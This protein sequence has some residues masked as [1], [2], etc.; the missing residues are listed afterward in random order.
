MKRLL[1]LFP[2]VLLAAALLAGC[3]AAVS[4]PDAGQEP[5]APSAESDADANGTAE[6]GAD[7][8]AL[9]RGELHFVTDQRGDTLYVQDGRSYLATVD[10]RSGTKQL[11]CSRPGCSHNGPDCDAWLGPELQDDLVYSTA[12]SDVFV[13]EDRLY[14]VF[15]TSPDHASGPYL[16]TLTVSAPDGSG[17]TLLCENFAPDGSTLDITWLADEEAL[18]AVFESNPPRSDGLSSERTVVLRIG[19]EDGS[20]QLLFDW[21]AGG[22][23]PTSTAQVFPAAVC[24]NQLVMGQS[25]PPEHHTGSMAD[26]AAAT[27]ITYHVLDLNTGTLGPEL[28][29]EQPSQTGQDG[30]TAL[31]VLRNG[32]VWQIDAAGTLT[33]R[34]LLTGQDLQQYP[35]LWPAGLE[36]EQ[37]FAVTDRCI[38]I[39]G[40]DRS[41]T[42]QGDLLYEPHRL[43]FDRA[44]GTLLRE[45]PATWLKDGASPRLPDLYAENGDRAILLVDNRLG[46]ATDM[47]QD[48]TVYT[49]PTGEPIYAVIDLDAYLDG[50]QDWT[51]CTPTDLGSVSPAP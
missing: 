1:G 40:A 46:T 6:S 13:E 41:A 35:G 39:D 49:H 27:S 14:R 9:P 30:S 10:F 26:D 28:P 21:S 16:S 50:S 8:A 45:L 31:F 22:E 4:M 11:L 38:A 5:S 19:K 37:L 12:Q 42:E 25:H 33:I 29:V 34:D 24:G 3:G 44:D 17:Q 7:I 18:Y 43:V 32:T 51:L 47:G 20:V 23:M 36:P 15:V 2:A 48:G